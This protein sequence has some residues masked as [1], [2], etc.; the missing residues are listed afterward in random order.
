MKTKLKGMSPEKIAAV[1]Q[2]VDQ[3]GKSV[4]IEF[5]WGGKIGST[6]DA[7]RLIHLGRESGES[8]EVLDRLVEG[9]FEA[10]HVKERDIA[11]AGVLREIAVEAGIEGDVVDGW[12]G[13]GRGGKEVD[14]EAERNKVRV[15]G[16]GVPYFVIGGVHVVDGAQDLGEFFKAFVKVKEGEMGTPH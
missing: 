16:R 2:R 9:L 11:D 8:E 5:S 7:H 6:R 15:G 14:E 10:Y 3:V 4:G 1:T 12:L 13:G